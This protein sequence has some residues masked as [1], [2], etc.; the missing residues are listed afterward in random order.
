MYP[1][2][3][4]LPPSGGASPSHNRATP[5]AMPPS[6]SSK[7]SPLI[8][9]ASQPS[10]SSPVT[11]PRT[12]SSSSSPS[13]A[14][15][16]STSSSNSSEPTQLNE[17]RLKKE[18]EIL[19]Q[20]LLLLQSKLK[21]GA[22]GGN[23]S[24]GL[25][26][27]ME[28]DNPLTAEGDNEGEGVSSRPR[29]RSVS[30][31]DEEPRWD[32]DNSA[33][34]AV[35]VKPTPQPRTRAQTVVVGCDSRKKDHPL[36]YSN[37]SSIGFT[38]PGETSSRAPPKSSVAASSSVLSSSTPRTSDSPIPKPRS[39]ATS[40]KLTS[41]TVTAVEASRAEPQQDSEGGRGSRGEGKVDSA[42]VSDKEKRS[43]SA[44]SS[45]SS[46]SGEKVQ[47]ALTLQKLL[48]RESVVKGGH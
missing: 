33:K 26:L 28:L 18:N 36:P 16:N 24:E 44:G 4:L 21:S 31:G 38:T 15:S 17:E 5:S 3:P 48:P 13:K 43:D 42:L 45:H 9:K 46:S 37:K 39:G 6:S 20:Q 27:L 19:K 1:R 32:I 47:A 8:P 10:K 40:S 29:S 2:V 30:P 22:M 35:K 7:K 41:S 23:T 34:H 14:H 25:D 12:D 11:T